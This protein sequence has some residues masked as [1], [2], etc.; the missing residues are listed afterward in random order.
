M[1]AIHLACLIMLCGCS[2]PPPGNALFGPDETRIDAADQD[3]ILAALGFIEETTAEGTRL[4]D[5]YC[6]AVDPRAELVDLDEDGRFEVFVLWGN[7]CTSGHTG[8]SIMLFAK[9]AGGNYDTHLGFPAAAYTIHPRAGSA[10]PD[11]ELGGPG[12]CA[13]VWRWT[14][15]TYEHLCNLPEGDGGCTEQGNVCAVVAPDFSGR[16]SELAIQ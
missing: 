11:L 3:V 5:A 9:N 8:S 14:G 2:T 10:F 12:F 13:P 7:T 1:R 4:V 6:G 15:A 16:R